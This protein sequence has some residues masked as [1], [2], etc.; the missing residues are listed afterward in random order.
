MNENENDQV[1]T[2]SGE[3]SHVLLYSFCIKRDR[4]P[5]RPAP[6]PFNRG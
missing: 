6:S 3:I 5:P 1:R 4:R 2:W